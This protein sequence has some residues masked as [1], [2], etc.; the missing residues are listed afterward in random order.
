MNNFYTNTIDQFSLQ[1]RLLYLLSIALSSGLMQVACQKVK[2][3]AKYESKSFNKSTWVVSES[4][5]QIRYAK[6]N[7]NLKCLY[8][9]RSLCV[10]HIASNIAKKVRISNAQLAIRWQSCYRL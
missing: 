7:S 1:M 3:F 8:I 9:V 2:V 6:K 5:E 10:K 4:H